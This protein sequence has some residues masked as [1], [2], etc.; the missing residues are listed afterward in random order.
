M[1]FHIIVGFILPWVLG[2]YLFRNQT[3]LF[4]IFYPIGSTVSFLINEIGFTY[5]WEMG[6][7]FA[8]I[9][10]DLGLYPIACCLFICSIHFK[11]MSTLPTFL[12]FTL[13]TNFLELL[14]VLLGKL[15]YRNGWNIYWSAV[16]YLLAYLIVYGYYQLVRAYFSFNTRV[17]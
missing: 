1:L 14:I 15:E 8:P 4:I 12:V 9:W 5:F 7:V 13:G 11:K 16:S 10:Y 17:H 2:L 6:N 3:R